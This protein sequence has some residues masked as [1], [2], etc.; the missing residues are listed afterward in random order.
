M[1][2]LP[3]FPLIGSVASRIFY[4]VDVSGAPVP[5][6]GPVMLAANHANSLL[7]PLLVMLAARRPVRFVAKSTLFSD[8]VIGWAAN[9]VGAIPVYRRKDDPGQVGRNEETFRAVHDALEQ[10]AA[11]GIFPEGI[12]HDHPSLV[13]LKTGTARIALGAAA[14]DGRAFPIVPIGL[15]FEAK[16]EFRSRAHVL[17]G[18]PVEWA[19]LCRDGDA[20]PA[21]VRELTRRIQQALHDVT[22]NYERWEDAGLVATATRIYGA[23]FGRAADPEEK[24][25]LRME[26]ARLLAQLHLDGDPEA[27]ALT[28]AIERHART[29]AILGLAP[30][31]VHRPTDVTSAF[32]WTA[33][34]L[35][36]T[37][38][39]TAIIAVIGVAIFWV[40]Y[41]LTRL[42]AER[43]AGA[44]D[45]LAMHK[46]LFG[47]GIFKAWIIALAITLGFIAQWWLGVIAVVVLPV[48]ALAT[49]SYGERWIGALRDIRSFFV[50]RTRGRTLEGLRQRQ[51]LLAGRLRSLYSRAH[52]PGAPV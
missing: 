5:H 27:A 30:S 15:I 34:R 33:R 51:R 44:P 48:L 45:A 4:R 29:L 41:R 18:N 21:K 31:D 23:E 13:P 35:S 3:I 49:L 38:I 22:V 37:A 47:L 2:L 36:P 7:D 40:P 39:M 20:T 52:A 12:S 16:E 26:A 43:T 32:K 50:L 17:V 6:R 46:L 24:V 14:R 1:W 9:A 10:G 25:I 28:H 42:V 19:D 11:V 8:R